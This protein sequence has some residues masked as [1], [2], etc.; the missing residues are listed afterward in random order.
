VN[1][2]TAMARSAS[3]LSLRTRATVHAKPWDAVD[4]FDLAHVIGVEVRFTNI[5]SME[6]MYLRQQSPLILIA[7]ER[8]PGRQRFTCAHEL[9]HH[10]F[11]DGSRI[12]EL[13]DIENSLG[14]RSDEEVR[15]DM[16]AGLLLMPKTAVLRG[17][18]ARKLCVNTASAI[19]VFRVSCWLGVGYSTLLKHLKFALHIIPE[20]RF[21]ELIRHSPKSIR[22]EIL[23]RE[24][25]EDLVVVDEH[26]DGR[27]VDIRVGDLLLLPKDSTVEGQCCTKEA[28]SRNGALFKAVRPGI[29]RFESPTGWAAFAR[30]S[31]KNYEG[32]GIFRHLEEVDDE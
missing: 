20:D 22:H 3:T 12:D 14:R 10:V 29:G 2:R 6:G 5:P 8:P 30:V 25:P 28:N 27:P 4:V 19:D 1:T 18:A 17:F 16:F 9:G 13:L 11:G 15:A 21:T 23:E 7:S 32:R 26:W 24:A 31:R